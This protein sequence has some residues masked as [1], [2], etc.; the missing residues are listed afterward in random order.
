MSHKEGAFATG[1][2]IL[3]VCENCCI[4]PDTVNRQIA[5]SQKTGLFGCIT[6]KKKPQV[7][8]RTGVRERPVVCICRSWTPDSIVAKNRVIW[9]SHKEG[10]FAT[11]RSILIVCENCCIVPDTANRQIALFFTSCLIL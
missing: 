1:R 5:K 4:V 11:G 9:M 2:S 6:R 7:S 8:W 10:A 3:V